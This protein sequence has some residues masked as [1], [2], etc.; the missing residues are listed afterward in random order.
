MWA[1][2]R[3]LPGFPGWLLRAHR[4]L[5]PLSGCDMSTAEESGLAFFPL[6][7]VFV[8]SSVLIVT[9]IYSGVSSITFSH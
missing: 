3:L 5:A 1:I 6:S 2:R 7:S 8:R 4:N 9:D